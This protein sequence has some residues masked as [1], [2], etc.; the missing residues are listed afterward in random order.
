[1]SWTEEDI[2]EL[3]SA[4]KRGVRTVAVK[5]RSITYQSVEEMMMVLAAMEDE[6]AGE[7]STVSRR[8]TYVETRKGS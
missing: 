5:D 3:K 2:A 4:I 6:V 7:T 8:T 1:M